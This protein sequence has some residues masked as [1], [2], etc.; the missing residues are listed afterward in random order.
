MINVDLIEV[1]R[2][3]FTM[4]I[5]IFCSII[6]LSF[7]IERWWFFRMISLDVENFMA[8]LKKYIEE[9]NF[10]EALNHC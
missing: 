2:K 7:A 6:A 4:F 3:S 9:G 5:L 8:A 10:K 1:I